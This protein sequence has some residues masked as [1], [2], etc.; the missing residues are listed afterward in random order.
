[1]E[2]VV[3]MLHKEQTTPET[4]RISSL[5]KVRELLELLYYNTY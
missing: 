3:T 5:I 1:M 2:R 4:K